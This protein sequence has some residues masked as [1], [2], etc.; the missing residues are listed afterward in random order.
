MIAAARHASRMPG[1][2]VAEVSLGVTGAGDLALITSPDN[3]TFAHGKKSA[4]REKIASTGHAKRVLVADG[5][6]FE[7]ENVVH[8]G[9]IATVRWHEMHG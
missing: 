4:L 7:S 8:V 6:A 9:D 3:Y 2:L 5:V 1:W